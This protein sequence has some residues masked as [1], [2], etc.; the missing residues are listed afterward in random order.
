MTPEEQQT[1]KD[2]NTGLKENISIRLALSS[3][4]QKEPLS[5]FCEE[6]ALFAPKITVENTK[7]GDSSSSSIQLRKNL[8]FHAIPLGR[9]LEPFL[10]ILSQ[11]AGSPLLADETI[12]K[13]KKNKAPTF[14]KLFIVQQCP[15]CPDTLRRLAP[16]T[17][18]SELIFLTVIDGTLFYEMAQADNVLSAPTILL[19]DSF[20]WSG[21]TGLEEIAEIILNRDPATLSASSLQGLI[22]EGDAGRVAEMMLEN[23]LIFPEFI[24]LLTHEKWPIRLGAMVAMEEVADRDIKLASKAVKPL[25]DSFADAEDQVRGDIVYII[26]KAGGPETIGR[27]KGLTGKNHSEDVRDAAKDAINAITE[28]T[29]S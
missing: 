18:I 13:L 17:Q 8:R 26:G 15:H 5:R 19:E 10:E 2:W 12:K 11:S 6:L 25:W 22:Q 4:D 16:L 14:L 27:L 7:A 3:D 1:I 24:K 20:R 28:R 21:Q 23:N 29:D 9:E